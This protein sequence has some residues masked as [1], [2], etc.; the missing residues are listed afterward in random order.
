[1]KFAGID[2]GARIIAAVPPVNC[3]SSS[4]GTCTLDESFDSSLQ[5]S[6][7][8]ARAH[9][10]APELYRSRP[11][12]DTLQKADGRPTLVL[13]DFKGQGRATVFQNQPYIK[14]PI[15]FFTKRGSFDHF[16][17]IFMPNYG[18]KMISLLMF[19]MYSS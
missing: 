14:V 2:R 6:A 16:F 4:D 17:L 1:M 11:T 10:R 5:I 8:S 19:A 3:S 9:G 18:A 13:P 15:V 7:G 12:A